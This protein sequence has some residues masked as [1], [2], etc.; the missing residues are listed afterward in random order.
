[1]GNL[2]VCCDGTW[3]TP[4]DEQGGVPVPTNVVRIYNALAEVDSSGQAQRK[5]YHPGVGTDGGWWQRLIGGGLGVG[6]DGNIMSAYRWL[7]AN[8]KKND[9]IFLFGFSRG[10]FTVRSLAGMISE[11]GLLDLSGQDDTEAWSR[12]EKAYQEGYRNLRPVGDWAGSW[13]FHHVDAPE[14]EFPVYFLGVWDTVGALGIP[15]DLAILNLIDNPRRYFF[16]HTDLGNNVLNARHAVALDE[17]RASFTPTLW[18][19]IA[20]R[21]TAKQVWFPG[22]H[23]DVGGG[24]AEH[25][26]SDAALKWMLDEA[27]TLGLEFFQSMYD[28]VAPNPQGVLHD[29]TVGAFRLLRTQPRSVPPI[30]PTTR[31][32]LHDSVLARQ[33]TPPLAQ[34]NY[35]PTTLLRK[36]EEK[37]VTIFASQHWNDTGIYLEDGAQYAFEASGE[38]LDGDIKCGPDGPKDGF[39]VEKLAHVFGDA[40]GQ[41][42][43]AYKILTKNEEAD[44]KSSRREEDM[45][46]FALV[47]AIAN[48]GNPGQDG[49]P[50]PPEVFL[51]GKNCRYPA[52]GSNP[53]RPGYLYC[54]ANDAWDF[55]FN[56]RGSVVLKV[57]RLS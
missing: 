31:D 6:L 37:T 56:N 51:I 26:L 13:E 41:I 1:M 46:W 55:Y 15:N 29:S 4:E 17:K 39:Q 40:A 9:R 42:E 27:R 8:Y 28:Q 53:S 34:A 54:F 11:C 49:T 18:T 19:N 47:G 10:A 38:W 3:N 36:G 32:I 44:L 33:S 23:C 24:Y 20:Q 30:L 7:G 45:P 22:V 2:I 43:K 48:G 57:T 14:A 16:H 52:A 35:R 12:V 50:Q 25:G 5:Y 21:P